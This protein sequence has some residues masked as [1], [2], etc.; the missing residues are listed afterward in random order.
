MLTEARHRALIR[1]LA[2]Q[3]EVTLTEAANRFRISL[4]TVRRDFQALAEAGHVRRV[5]GAILPPDFSLAEPRYTR[6]ASQAA[7]LKVRLAEAA[8]A[9]L[10][11]SG[12]VFIDA[13]TSCLEV[14]RQVLDRPQLRIFTNSVSILALAPEARA[15]LVSIGGEVR[16]VSLALTGGFAQSWVKSLHFDASVVGAS[17]LSRTEGPCTTELT[18]AAIKAEAMRRGRRR[19]L[20]A[21]A[22]KW[23]RPAAVRFAPWDAFTDWVTDQVLASEDRQRLAKVGVRTH[24]LSNR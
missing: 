11:E 19:I 21:H 14:A 5:H 4:P 6:K 12:A 22:E 10:P 18:E 13:G 1:L 8:V 24:S 2:E 3:G 15:S 20:V 16:G 7:A 17:G 9:L 23:D